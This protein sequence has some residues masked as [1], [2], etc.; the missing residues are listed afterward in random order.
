MSTFSP[1]VPRPCSYVASFFFF[2][3]VK[4]PGIWLPSIL[5]YASIRLL[6]TWS[7]AVSGYTRRSLKTAW[8]ML[9][10]FCFVYKYRYVVSC[11]YLYS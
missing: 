9:S 7:R 5:F 11:V 10:I 3:F 1:L 6:R 2:D 4:S 8:D